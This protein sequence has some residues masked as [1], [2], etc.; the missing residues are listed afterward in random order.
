MTAADPPPAGSADPPTPPVGAAA[1]VGPERRY[2][3]E[4]QDRWSGYVPRAGDVV[5]STRSKCGTTWVQAACLHLVHGPELPA[6]LSELSPWLDWDVE[7]VADVLARLDA[8]PHRRVIKT[9][10]PLAG[11]PLHAGVHHVVVGRHPLDV[12]VSLHHHALNID[13]RRS[14]EL[15]GRPVGPA[16]A[17]DVEEWIEGWLAPGVGPEVE[18]DTLPGLVHHVT[19][20][21]P[22]RVAIDVHL[23]HHRDLVDDLDGELGR[24]AQALGIELDP[25][26]RPGLV[27]ALS[28]E[29]MRSRS[30]TYVPD[31]LG[32]LRDHTRFFRSGT[33]GDGRRT[34]GP[35]VE[36]RCVGAVQALAPPDVAA[37]LL[38]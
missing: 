24:L 8:Q 1:P 13:R 28:F 31:R 38:R 34:L 18:L 36:E 5:V 26:L 10:T 30:A 33:P 2:A 29:A 21:W 32:V 37:W 17:A 9:H 22:R 15:R 3:S 20:A 6:P 12:A 23:V 19:D 16:P 14:A 11:I 4:A 25:D 7:P 27:A 35:E